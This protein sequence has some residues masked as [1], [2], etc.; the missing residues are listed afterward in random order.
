MKSKKSKK[1]E[2]IEIETKFQSINQS[3]KERFIYNQ[4]NEI[5]L[6]EN[7]ND[8]QEFIYTNKDKYNLEITIGQVS[9]FLNKI[10]IE[11]GLIK[12]RKEINQIKKI[13]LNDS[14]ISETD[15]GGINSDDLEKL[16]SDLEIRYEL[17]RDQI[18]SI[19]RSEAK[20]SGYD[21]PKKERVQK[22]SIWKKLIVDGMRDKLSDKEISESI[23]PYVKN[24]RCSADY[25]RDYKL[26]ISYALNL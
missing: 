11:E 7:K 5:N 9:N 3:V 15:L 22:L 12:S 2:S 23:R 24:D 4:E 25:V 10:L 8:L 26:I 18:R 21:L 14:Q 20:K 19:I 1:S 17:T 6:R 13:C 16:I